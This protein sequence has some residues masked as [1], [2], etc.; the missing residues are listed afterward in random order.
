MLT[1]EEP[2]PGSGAATGRKE[3]D[4]DGE[5]REREMV[6]QDWKALLVLGVSLS[7]P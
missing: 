3:E 4:V 1:G 5:N 7:E 6:F 2:L